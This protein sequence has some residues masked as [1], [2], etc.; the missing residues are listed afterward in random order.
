M[1]KQSEAK[2]KQGYV[3]IPLPKTCCN[4]A[5]FRVAVEHTKP[6]WGTEYQKE[7]NLYCSV[8]G[9]AVTWMATCNAFELPK[10]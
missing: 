2:E 7:T 8:G 10:A 3:A 9:F 4:C 1:S 5:Y 6:A